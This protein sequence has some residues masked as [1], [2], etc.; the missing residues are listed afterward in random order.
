MIDGSI[1]H[2]DAARL[3]GHNIVLHHGADG[4]RSGSRDESVGDE[5][6]IGNWVNCGLCKKQRGEELQR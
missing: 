6:I 5:K 2:G 3:S 4:T 1:G